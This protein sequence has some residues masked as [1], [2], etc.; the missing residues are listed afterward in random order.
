MAILGDTRP[1][2]NAVTLARGVDVLVHE[3]TYRADQEERAVEYHHST[4]VQA[5]ETAREAG[6]GALIL[7]HIS[8][9]YGAEEGGELLAEARR[10]SPIH[11][12]PMTSGRIRY[13]NKGEQR[14]KNIVRKPGQHNTQGSSYFSIF[15]IT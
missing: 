4:S 12:W 1:T 11:I 7:T 9:R 8:A 5:A 14:G 6:A 13:L 2:A 3:A 15:F 10:F